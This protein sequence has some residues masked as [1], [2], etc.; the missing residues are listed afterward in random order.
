MRSVVKGNYIKGKGGIKHAIAHVRYLQLRGGEDRDSTLGKKRVFFSA[1]HENISG[2]EV[3]DQLNK[4]RENGVVAFRLVLSPGLEGVDMQAYTRC[5][6]RELE[7]LKGQDLIYYAIEHKNTDHTHNH[8]IIMGRDQNDRSVRIT[9]GHY[10]ALRQA[11]DRYLERYH[12]YER[13]LDREMHYLMRD[14]YRYGRVLDK[15][16]Y[17]MMRDGYKRDQ[18]DQLYELLQDD[19]KNPLTLEQCDQQRIENA[20]IE[21][22]LRI[23]A[24]PDSERIVRNKTVYTKYSSLQELLALDAALQSRQC[25]RLPQEQ[26]KKMWTWIGNKKQFG[27]DYYERTA[28]ADRLQKQFDEDLKQSLKTDNSPPK[29]FKQHV[30]ETGGRLLEWHERYLLDTEHYQVQKTITGLD[31]SGEEDPERR[32]VLIDQLEWLNSL[33]RERCESQIKRPVICRFKEPK[34]MNTQA[35]SVRSDGYLALNERENRILTAQSQLQ[36]QLRQAQLDQDLLEKQLER[37]ET[38]ERVDHT[39]DERVILD[40]LNQARETEDWNQTHEIHS[41]QLQNQDHINENH[42][43][44]THNQNQIHESHLTQTHNQN[45]TNE[46]HPTQTQNNVQVHISHSTHGLEQIRT[47]ESDATLQVHLDRDQSNQDKHSDEV[48][49]TTRH[50]A[51]RNRTTDRVRFDAENTQKRYKELQR[52]KLFLNEDGQK[53]PDTFSSRFQQLIDNIAHEFVQKHHPT[54]VN[55]GSHD[56]NNQKHFNNE[57][58]PPPKKTEK[59]FRDED[60]SLDQ[61][62]QTQVRSNFTDSID[63]AFSYERHYEHQNDK[64]NA[65]KRN[66]LQQKEPHSERDDGQ[67]HFRESERR[68]HDWGGEHREHD[69][70]D[71]GREHER[72]R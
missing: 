63:K 53:F 37:H 25:K 36:E 19:L 32:K 62:M 28:E 41:S 8:V 55:F 59:Q 42:P 50:E 16:M 60:H 30:F 47:P 15:E 11:G 33:I 71:D 29:S 44:Q 49:Q 64:A 56:Q 12:T 23:N 35:E 66:D 31:Q 57:N 70:D 69:R 68:V 46:R 67:D 54:P 34:T 2:T 13:Y 21:K 5:M 65:V 10:K 14:G 72:G 40:A 45:Q 39:I 24:L 27:N 38:L 43:T 4:Q 20:A 1:T 52:L 48:A 58:L 18:G 7:S 17:A 61:V 3:V 9:R 51:D 6:M 26:Y 22:E